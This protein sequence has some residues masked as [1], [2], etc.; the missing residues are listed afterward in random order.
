MFS[1]SGLG[2]AACLR[3]AQSGAYVAI[4]DIDAVAGGQV[5]AEMVSNKGKFFR[6]DISDTTSISTAISRVLEWA[7]STGGRVGGVVAA[8]GVGSPAKVARSLIPTENDIQVD[9]C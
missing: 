5:L 7:E 3:L 4:L 2:R 9:I 8:A 6:V 1:G